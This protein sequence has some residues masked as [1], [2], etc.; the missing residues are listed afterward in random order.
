M[1]PKNTYLTRT[2]RDSD[3][4]PDLGTEG[5]EQYFS[6]YQLLPTAREINL[7]GSDLHSKTEKEWCAPS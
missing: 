5:L 7:V 1:E 4:G 2:P 3:V 6:S